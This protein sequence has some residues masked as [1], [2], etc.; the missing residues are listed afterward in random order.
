M[1][2]KTP[3]PLS[4]IRLHRQREEKEAFQA[5]AAALKKWERAR[6][7]ADDA[8]WEF[9]LACAELQQKTIAGTANSEIT[10]LRR[11]CRKLQENSRRLQ[12][13]SAEAKAE[14]SAAFTVLANARNAR[15]TMEACDDFDSGSTIVALNPVA[16]DVHE[17]AFLWN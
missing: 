16:A 7:R 2:I 3:S 4:A 10:S 15:Q 11:H 6:D 8:A 14:A 5:Y 1:I 9:Q 17:T 13:A 12:I